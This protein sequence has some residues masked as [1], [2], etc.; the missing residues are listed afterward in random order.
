MLGWYAWYET[1][2][3]FWLFDLYFFGAAATLAKGPI[4]TFLALGIILLFLGLRREWSALRRTIW[5]PWL[6]LYLLMVLPWYIAV[7]RKNPHFFRIFFLEHNLE[8]FATDRYQHSPAL[9]LLRRRAPHRPD[10]LDRRLPSAPLATAW[11][12]PSPSGR[13]ATSP[14][15]TSATSA[16][17]TP[18]PSSSCSGRCFPSSSSPSRCPSCPA[19]S[20]LP[21]R[22][23][24]S[25]PATTSTASG[26]T[27]SPTGCSTCTPVSPAL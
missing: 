1:G 24:P 19:T 2:K 14:S 23:S 12:S 5:L 4:A 13:S 22:R 20:C 7:Q 15:A 10:A 6:R 18:S 21:S 3:K 27:V 16:Q 26:A 17:A 9:V 11:R 25:S 8:R